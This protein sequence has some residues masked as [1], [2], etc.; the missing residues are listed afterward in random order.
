MVENP[1]YLFGK[2]GPLHGSITPIFFIVV[3]FPLYCHFP[4]TPTLFGIKWQGTSSQGSSNNKQQPTLG[5]YE[6]RVCLRFLERL[7]NTQSSFG[8]GYPRVK[9]PQ[10]PWVAR[11]EMFLSK[12][13][14]ALT[15]LI[16]IEISCK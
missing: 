13:L 9:K 3:S 6:N 15:M 5:R 11:L 14:S 4:S 10:I 7:L 1:K 2:V 8:H 16:E 12:W